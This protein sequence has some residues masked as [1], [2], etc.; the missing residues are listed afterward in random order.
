MFHD[1]PSQ[2]ADAVSMLKMDGNPLLDV[3]LWAVD[4]V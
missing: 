4:D 2:H 1:L 3:S